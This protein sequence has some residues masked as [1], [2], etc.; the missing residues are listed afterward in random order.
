MNNAVYGAAVI[1]WGL[2]AV[3][4]L[5][6]LALHQGN[7]VAVFCAVLAAGLT[8]VYQ[9]CVYAEIFPKAQLAL[10][11]AI[12]AAWTVGVTLLLIGA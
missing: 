8:Y 11:I 5:F 6:V 12:I 7:A 4:L 2:L 3:V 1:A 10:N 9:S